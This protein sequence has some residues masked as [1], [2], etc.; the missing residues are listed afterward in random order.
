MIIY[1]WA[2]IISFSKL[3]RPWYFSDKVRAQFLSENS[4]ASAWNCVE[5]MK[6]PPLVLCFRTRQ[7]CNFSFLF[8]FFFVFRSILVICIIGDTES[9][10]TGKNQ[11]NCTERQQRRT[12][13]LNFCLKNSRMKS[14]QRTTLTILKRNIPRYWAKISFRDKITNNSSAPCGSVCVFSR[15]NPNKYVASLGVIKVQEWMN[16]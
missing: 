14:K 9:T 3:N 8:F 13:T 15:D 11:E 10:K 5:V 2:C 6:A 16:L 12:K 1:L 4:R 7:R